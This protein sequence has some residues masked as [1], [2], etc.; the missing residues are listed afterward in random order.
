[1]K[2]PLQ[3][4]KVLDLSRLLPGPLCTHFLVRMGA[5]VVKIEGWQPDSADY[6]R[7][8][9]PMVKFP[10]GTR[11]GAVFEALNAQ[12]QNVIIDFKHSSGAAILRRLV[13]SYDIL[14]EGNRPGVMKR[15]GISYEELKEENPRLIY[16]SIT[17][18]GATGPYAR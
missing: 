8:L 10:D 5:Q 3:G 2:G 18:Y 9:P 17:G 15:L 13:K 12:K 7:F 14:V 4:L 11:H 6:V 16:C 1:M